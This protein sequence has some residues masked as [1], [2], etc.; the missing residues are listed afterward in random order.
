M[1]SHAHLEEMCKEY[2]RVYAGSFEYY[3]RSVARRSWNNFKNHEQRNRMRSLLIGR[4]NRCDE[5]LTE[6]RRMAQENNWTLPGPA[7]GLTSPNDC[8]STLID[9]DAR[10]PCLPCSVTL[11]VFECWQTGTCPCCNAAS[12]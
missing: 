1:E 10:F 8:H 4:R 5:V 2:A 11:G 7:T 9:V 12:T 3:S 6:L